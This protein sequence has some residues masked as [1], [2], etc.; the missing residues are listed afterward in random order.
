MVTCVPMDWC[1]AQQQAH[2]VPPCTKLSPRAMNSVATNHCQRISQHASIGK[3]K[4]CE[5][6]IQSSKWENAYRI[7]GLYLLVLHYCI[8]TDLTEAY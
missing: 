8:S 5:A 4:T 3:V 2:G 7:V 6:E 1:W